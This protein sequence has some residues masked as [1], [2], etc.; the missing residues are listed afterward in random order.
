MPISTMSATSETTGAMV[1]LREIVGWPPVMY[2]IR[3]ALP[4]SESKQ[5]SILFRLGLTSGEATAGALSFKMHIQYARYCIYV[6]VSTTRKVHDYKRFR[7][8]LLSKLLGQPAN[9]RD[10]M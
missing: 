3:A 7:G 1:E 9:H 10:R 5:R 2:R 6:L 8:A 4:S